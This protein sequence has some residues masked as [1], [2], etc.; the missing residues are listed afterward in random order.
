M[1]KP[2]NRNTNVI[3]QYCAGLSLIEL[4]VALTIGLLI[5][6][7]LATLYATTRSSYGE[8]EQSSRQ[9]ENGRYAMQVLS[10]EIQHTGFYGEYYNLDAPPGALPDPCS[11]VL[12]NLQAALP[13]PLQ[14]YDA[15]AGSPIACLNNANFKS[16]TDILVIRRA[17]TT[18]PLATT[19]VL[20]RAY[21]QANASQAEIQLG[22]PAGFVL[23]VDKADSTPATILKK[24]GV[25][26]ADIRSYR[27][28]IYFISPCDME[29]TNNACDATDDGGKPIPTLKRIELQ[30][31]PSWNTASLVQGIENFQVEYG[32]DTTGDGVPDSYYT[33]PADV[34]P[35]PANDTTDWSNVVALRLHLLA[36]N[37]DATPGHKGTKQYD[38]DSDPFNPPPP[39]IN[40]AYK[41]HVYT[42]LVRVNNLSDRKQL[43]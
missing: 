36:R 26:A 39:P 28:H 8:L 12:A 32:I 42:A 7:G 16:S 23:G 34:T 10:D 3:A 18:L 33:D 14:G 40:D 30:S 20:N 15:P 29:G 43:P 17:E 38:L 2:P 21:I 19:P 37:I 1:K 41:R 25:T 13:L 9:L 5:T 6:T 31:G 4:M 27:V 11:T 35:G 24:D 22:N